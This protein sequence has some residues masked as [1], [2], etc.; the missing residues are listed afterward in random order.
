MIV[1]VL[2]ARVPAKNAAQFE[3][4]LRDQ[5]PKMREHDGLVYLKLARQVKLDYEDVLLFEEWRDAKAL[6]GWAG[7]RLLAPR[8][9]PGAESLV[10]RV[11][12]THY[13]ALDVD[14][15]ELVAMSTSVADRDLDGTSDQD[16]A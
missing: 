11:E 2:T 14:P 3:S 13:E 6:Y 10:D 9:F 15:D 12:V 5:L 8:L 1:R 4:L 16:S 7:P